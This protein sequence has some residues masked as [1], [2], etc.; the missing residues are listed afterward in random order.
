MW[1]G[2]GGGIGGGDDGAGWSEMLG[3][4]VTYIHPHLRLGYRRLGLLAI[5]RVTKRSSPDS[6]A[7]PTA[8]Q[9]LFQHFDLFPDA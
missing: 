1:L 7:A 2:Y 5:Y 6:I 9:P 8:R 3:F 4:I